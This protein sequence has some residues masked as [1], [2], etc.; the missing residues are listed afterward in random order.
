M[1]DNCPRIFVLPWQNIQRQLVVHGL[2]TR[3]EPIIVH[4]INISNR[5]DAPLLANLSAVSPVPRDLFCLGKTSNSNLPAVSPDRRD[6]FGCPIRSLCFVLLACFS[7]LVF[8]TE[9]M[10]P[11]TGDGATGDSYSMRMQ[12]CDGELL[13]AATGDQVPGAGNQSADAVGSVYRYALDNNVPRLIGKLALPGRASSALYGISISCDATELFIGA[14][15]VA[16]LF[17]DTDAG[18][19]FRYRRVGSDWIFNG[20]IPGAR[21]RTDA[22]LGFSSALNS[23]WLLVGAPGEGAAYLYARSGGG[24]AAGVRIAPS[25]L[26]PSASEAGFGSEVAFSISA[27]QSEMAIAA[28]NGI[29]GTVIRYGLSAMPNELG[30]Q[31]G[32]GN[33]GAGLRYANDALWI[34]APTAMNGIGQVQVFNLQSQTSQVIAAPTYG[35]PIEFF[36][37][38][39]Q[40]LGNRVAVSATGAQLNG[41]SGEGALHIYDSAQTLVQSLRPNPSAN[42]ARADVFGKS[43]ALLGNNLFVGA[44]TADAARHPSQ[45]KVYQYD[46]ATFAPISTLDSGR[47]AAFDRFGSALAISGKRAIVGAFLVDSANGVETGEAYIYVRERGGWRLEATLVP[48]DALEEQRFGVAVDI[49]G[50]TAVIGSYWD[51]IG[52]TADAGSAYVFKRIRGV[53]QFT[54]KLVP[55]QPT[56]RGFFGFAVAIDHPRI[57]VGIRGDAL[58][59]FE[60]GAAQFFLEDAQGQFQAGNVIRLEQPAAGQFFGAAI[61]VQGDLAVVGAP[62]F[63][64][65]ALSD[66]GALFVYEAPSGSN[67]FQLLGS[68]TDPSATAGAGLGLSVSIAQETVFGGAPFQNTDTLGGVGRVLQ[69]SARV[70]A[71]MRI[72]DS[73][74]PQSGAQFG[75]SLSARSDGVWIGAPG[76]DVDS[77]SDVGAA[78]FAK[79]AGQV[80]QALTVRNL[81]AQLGRAVAS[82]EGFAI[83]GAPR[84]SAINPE[85]G[86]FYE[87]E[88]D[89]LFGDGFE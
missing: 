57:A 1:V 24:L 82:A 35:G 52:Q 10:P 68:R 8:A 48:P 88:G 55:Q 54:Q 50:D 27:S 74:I 4:M 89:A 66:T 6:L 75:S 31:S 76:L 67:R 70:S 60:Q 19:V 80:R 51:A 69:F 79:N 7:T 15:G 84:V 58:D 83:A 87:I 71:P 64:S 46:A 61:D 59:F 45:G 12:S 72:T 56:L 30:R 38:Q 63:S 43:S 40:L 2:C 65:G 62:G 41:N 53:W 16:S 5:V 11:T 85:E 23:Q 37:E 13:V 21:A 49:D 47:G 81:R 32:P 44:P 26:L 36:G 78:F 22:R 33:F 18:T 86:R 9:I 14:P 39:I 20:E 17:G 77:V 28:P 42:A 34:G 73:P 25:G 29:A 3:L